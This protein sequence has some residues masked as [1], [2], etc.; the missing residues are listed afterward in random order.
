[1]SDMNALAQMRHDF[2]NMYLIVVRNDAKVRVKPSPAEL[3]K[4]AF[5]QGFA[6]FV[7]EAG[8]NDVA[9]ELYDAALEITDLGN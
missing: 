5:L 4:Q 9:D 6:E 7:E 2:P 1:M 8:L 3:N